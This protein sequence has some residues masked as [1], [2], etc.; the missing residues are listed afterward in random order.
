MSIYLGDVSVEEIEQRT[1]ILLSDEDKEY[2]KAHRQHKINNTK[3]EQGCWHCFDIPFSFNAGDE[4]TAEFYLDMFK[5]Y[6]WSQC[7]EPLQIVWG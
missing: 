7:K 6:D 2:L 5:K 3:I 1:G 4:E